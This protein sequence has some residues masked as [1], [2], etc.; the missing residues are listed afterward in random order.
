MG[1]HPH[2]AA[3]T[4][5]YACEMMLDPNL[6]EAEVRAKLFEKIPRDTLL[7]HFTG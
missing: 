1:A 3:A 4:L 7:W 5:A 6:P 2:Q